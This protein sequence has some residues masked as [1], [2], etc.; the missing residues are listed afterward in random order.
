[1]SGLDQ[2]EA[3]IDE[4]C[5]TNCDASHDTDG[6]DITTDIHVF[7]REL[8]QYHQPERRV[9]A[10]SSPNTELSS[11]SLLQSTTAAA[12]PA[13]NPTGRPMMAENSKSRS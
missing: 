10:C 3:A 1:M 5:C 2:P 4:H 11:S 9:G 7:E 13:S 12:I 8:D 6:K